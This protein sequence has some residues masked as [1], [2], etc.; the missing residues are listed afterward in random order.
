M[1][2]KN[3]LVRTTVTPE[4]QP[5]GDHTLENSPKQSLKIFA[6]ET[7]GVPRWPRP[8]PAPASLHAGQHIPAPADTCF[9]QILDPNPEVN[10]TL[11]P[12]LT[13]ESGSL[14]GL[15]GTLLCVLTTLPP[16]CQGQT[17]GHSGLPALEGFSLPG[18]V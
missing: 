18:P 8:I 4:W 9:L 2:G 5:L 6:V 15:C 12:T 16:P 7:V 1:G 10:Q 3:E 11:S 13:P 17:P 14:V